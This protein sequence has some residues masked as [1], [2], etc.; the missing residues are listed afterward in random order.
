M[1]FIVIHQVYE[2]WFKEVLHE[3][4]YLDRLLADG[5][6]PRAQHTL[7][8]VLTIFKI[9]VAQLDVLET[10]TPVE[11]LTFRD[12]LD[13]ASGFQSYQFRELEFALG[14]EERRGTRTLPEAR[15]RRALA[16]PGGT[17]G[18]PQPLGYVPELSRASRRLPVPEAP[19]TAGFF[20]LQPGVGGGAGN[21]RRNLPDGS[22]YHRPVRTVDRSR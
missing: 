21:P 10:M 9:L 16:P 8:R 19:A 1:L 4:G 15:Q 7:K 20:T 14:R 17:A 3:L 5:D 12:R 2:L 6:A 11:F 18:C 22:G 13:T